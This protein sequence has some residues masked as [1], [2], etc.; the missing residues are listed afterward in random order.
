MLADLTAKD[1]P[2]DK[3]VDVFTYNLSVIQHRHDGKKISAEINNNTLRSLLDQS[4]SSE[5]CADLSSS[6]VFKCCDLI[7]S[8]KMPDNKVLFKWQEN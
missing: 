1:L 6:I 3:E 2:T 4:F 7:I 5:W 8:N